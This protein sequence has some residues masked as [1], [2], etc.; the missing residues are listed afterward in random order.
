MTDEMDPITTNNNHQNRRLGRGI[1]MGNMYEAPRGGWN[2]EELELKPEY[3]RIIREG[4]FDSVRIPV[5]W[6]DYAAREAPY[7]IEPEFFARVDRSIQAALDA[8]LAVVLNAHHYEE[9]FTDPVGHEPRLLALWEQIASH[10]LGYPPELMFEVLNE[11]HGELTNLLWNPLLARGVQVIRQIDPRRTILV[12]PGVWNSI[13][14]LDGFEPPST[15]NLILSVHY[16]LPMQFTHQGAS[17]AEGSEAWMGTQWTG[18]EEEKLAIINDFNLADTFASTHNM[19]VNLGEFG[20]YERADMESR[21]RW[22][23]FIVLQC[24]ARGWSFHY[25]EFCAGFGAYDPEKGAW[26]EP[27]L[28]AIN[29]TS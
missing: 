23:E 1:N 16:Y 10:Y 28:H 29:P 8:G 17:W 21:A 6:S 7:A 9:I 2:S 14:G 26:R 5:R 15:Y 25:W 12:G 13:G 27:I 3:F 19:P 22:T 18:T 20:A 4:G 11:P 24:E